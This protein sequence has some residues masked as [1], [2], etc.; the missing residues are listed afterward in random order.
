MGPG[1]HLLLVAVQ[2]M[3][4]RKCGAHQDHLR[5]GQLLSLRARLPQ[6]KFQRVLLILLSTRH[7]SLE[8]ASASG[9]SWLLL[10]AMSRWRQ[11]A[12][13]GRHFCVGFQ[14]SSCQVESLHVALADARDTEE[15]KTQGCVCDP[16][17]CTCHNKQKV[18]IHRK[19][20]FVKE[21]LMYLNALDQQM[22]E[23]LLGGWQTSLGNSAEGQPCCHLSRAFLESI[24]DLPQ[25]VVLE[26]GCMVG[27]LGYASTSSTAKALRQAVRG[28]GLG[29]AASSARHWGVPTTTWLANSQP[30]FFARSTSSLSSTPFTCG[31]Q[32]ST[33]GFTHSHHPLASAETCCA[34]HP[35]SIPL[36]YQELL[37]MPLDPVNQMSS[38]SVA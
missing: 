21:L 5:F 8:Q 22:K 34:E 37:S 11:M 2:D 14:L 26:D 4:W 24:L 28:N 27:T 9:L 18:S 36:S 17:R 29:D 7:S 15:K 25:K 12:D 20:C 1:A 23:S 31:S 38:T 35:P 6:H 19:P 10:V 3:L 32:Q 13:S 16:G 33:F 30:L